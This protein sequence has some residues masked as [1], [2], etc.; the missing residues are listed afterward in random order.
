MTDLRQRLFDY[1][2]YATRDP[3]EAPRLCAEALNRIEQLERDLAQ[4]RV[5]MNLIHNNLGEYIDREG[6]VDVTVALAFEATR[7]AL[8]PGDPK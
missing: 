2:T 7:A 4:S 3:A 1:A 8:N 5:T 6:S